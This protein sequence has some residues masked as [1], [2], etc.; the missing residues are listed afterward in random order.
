MP[1]HMLVFSLISITPGQAH[2]HSVSP[3]MKTKHGEVEQLVREVT[4]S[5]SAQQAS[6]LNSSICFW[7]SGPNGA[8]WTSASPHSSKPWFNLSAVQSSHRFHW[9]Q[10]CPVVHSALSLPSSLHRL[11]IVMRFERNRPKSVHQNRISRNW[12]CVT[13]QES[14]EKPCRGLLPA[15]SSASHH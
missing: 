8:F 11:C 15:C 6:L 9:D 3:Q 2:A 14:W 12:S 1:T 5:S 13:S 7:P 10:T 4:T